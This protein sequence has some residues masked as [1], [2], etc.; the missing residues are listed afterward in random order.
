MS[1]DNN[2]EMLYTTGP[3]RDTVSKVLIGECHVGTRCL[4]HDEILDS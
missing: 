2:G 1:C 3:Y 4:E